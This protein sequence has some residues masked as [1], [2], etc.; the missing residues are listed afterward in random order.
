[1]PVWPNIVDTKRSIFVNIHAMH[2]V[3]CN[4]S[5]RAISAWRGKE[6]Q[7][8]RKMRGRKKF[9]LFTFI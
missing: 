4:A 3:Y 1:M 9:L 6:G 7:F 5:F 8:K 2:A